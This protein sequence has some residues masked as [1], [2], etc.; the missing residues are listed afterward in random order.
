MKDKNHSEGRDLYYTQENVE[1]LVNFEG[2]VPQLNKF[3]SAFQANLFKRRDRCYSRPAKLAYSFQSSKFMR[4]ARI[5][6]KEPKSLDDLMAMCH[7]DQ[8]FTCS[9]RMCKTVY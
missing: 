6:A 7:K 8:L 1:P 3:N 2:R 4:V 9:A 5:T